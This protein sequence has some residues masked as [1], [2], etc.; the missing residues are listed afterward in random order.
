[1]RVH[2]FILLCCFGVCRS[3]AQSPVGKLPMDSCL[4]VGKLENGL[5]Y[6]IRHNEKPKGQADFLIVQKVGSMQEEETQQGLAHFLEHMCFQGTRHYPGRSMTSYLE[7]LGVKL[8]INLNAYTSFDETVF[9]I[10]NVP[11]RRKSVVDSCLLILHDWAC[12][13]SLSTKAIDD[14][15]KVI[16]EEWRTRQNVTM[17]MLQEVMPVVFPDSKYA[18]RLPIGLMEV[19]DNFPYKLLYDYYRK[20]YRPDLQ[21][22]I[23]VG[24]VEVDMVEKEITRLFGD[25][26]LIPDAAPRLFEQIA[27]NEQPIVATVSDR[28]QPITVI[29]L[30]Q[31]YHP[32]STEQKA[33]TEYYRDTY[34]KTLITNMFNMRMSEMI[35][36]SDAPF[37]QASIS[38]GDFL[39]AKS[40]KALTA[41]VVCREDK[42]I[43]GFEALAQEME[44]VRRF[45]F[46]EAEF[47]H[48][49][50]SYRTMIEN[51]YKERHNTRN[52]TFSSEYVRCFLD[53]EPSPG[54]SY[55]YPLM[56]RLTKEV[57][58]DD[59]NRI[60]STLFG[61]QNRVV[62]A[63]YPSK[64]N[65]SYPDS[66]ALAE[67]LHKVEAESL[68]P[69]GEVKDVRPLI[70][71]KLSGG[72]VVKSE[73]GVYGSTLYTLSNG[74]K[75]VIKHTDLKD[76]EI[77][78]AAFSPGGKSLLPADEPE[79]TVMLDE[80]ATI[81][82]YGDFDRL[83]LTKKLS[84]QKAV[85]GF[86]VGDYW[87]TGGG[88]CSKADFKTMLRLLYLSFTSPRRDDGAFLAFK[89]RTRET[90]TATASQSTAIYADSIGRALY[91]GTPPLRRAR[92]EHLAQMDYGRILQLRRERVA[93]AS[94]FTFLFVG[95]VRTED[96]PLI[97]KYIGS[98]PSL[99]RKEKCG[100]LWHPLRKGNYCTDFGLQMET[101]KSTVSLFL[102]GRTKDNFRNRL[103]LQMLVQSLNTLY[104]QTLREKEGGTYDVKVNGSFRDMFHDEVLVSINFDTSNDRRHQLR[105]K[106]LEL[107]RRFAVD[108]PTEENLAQIRQFMLK[109]HNDATSSNAYWLNL[110]LKCYQYDTDTHR[111]YEKLVNDISP[112]EIATF[113]RRILKQDNLVE[114]TMHG[115]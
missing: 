17:R 41:V 5:T 56:C 28:E 29:Q 93:D 45:G 2:T 57:S 69:Y 91:T 38:N 49:A 26:P 80:V 36:K 60:A 94:D 53:G 89:E 104:Q 110:L 88:S 75:V 1:M 4:R 65:R 8:G 39:I 47:Q 27:D 50:V 77:L 21:G 55:E 78:F 67:Y 84:G 33:T 62:I 66:T 13:L 40:I 70:A 16:H 100:V 115:L 86:F 101:P 73:E 114:V 103:I 90:L 95:N 34:C 15:R 25:I 10:S 72:K 14:E 111:N 82:G 37:L 32:L 61:K 113:A 44:R 54:I 85:C 83:A 102:H 12:D 24:D 22:I 99:H 46:T 97:E 74:A 48:A 7:G 92:P 109:S 81:G 51:A 19:V 112:K 64:E 71:R 43:V 76:N 30:I 6:Y 87:E 52:S 23:V 96:I 35:Q 68:M 108:G 58:L 42:E 20:W 107:L 106:A 63:N 3:V 9:N 105:D 59:V 31:K 98:L 79:N 11:V 18:Q